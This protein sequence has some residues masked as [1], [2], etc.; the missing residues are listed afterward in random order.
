MSIENATFFTAPEQTAPNSIMC[1]IDGATHCIPIDVTNGKYGVILD[2]IIRDGDEF[3]NEPLTTQVL[4][5]VQER[6][7]NPPLS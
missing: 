5:H 3:F 4:Q 1:T 7:D 2:K 6:I